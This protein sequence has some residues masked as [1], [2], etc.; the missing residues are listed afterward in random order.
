M[1]INTYFKEKPS[2]HHQKYISK[3]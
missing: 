1:E 3:G 2:F